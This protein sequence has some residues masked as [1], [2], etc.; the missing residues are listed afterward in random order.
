MGHKVYEVSELFLKELE[1]TVAHFAMGGREA[2]RSGLREWLSH[3]HWALESDRVEHG[4]DR[5]VRGSA[6]ED[7]FIDLLG[8]VIKVISCDD[9]EAFP[10][11][12]TCAG[13]LGIPNLG[14]FFF[15][16]A[17][18]HYGAYYADAPPLRLAGRLFRVVELRAK[19]PL[20]IPS[21][22]DHGLRDS[23]QWSDFED[24]LHKGI[25]ELHHNY[26][27][28]SAPPRT[29]HMFLRRY[30]WWIRLFRNKVEDSLLSPR[31][32]AKL[33]RLEE[34][35]AS[36][37]PRA[38]LLDEVLSRFSVALFPHDETAHALGRVSHGAH[39]GDQEAL[40]TLIDALRSYAARSY[41]EG[42]SSF[43]EKYSGQKELPL[44][45]RESWAREA[46][47]FAALLD[48]LELDL[49]MEGA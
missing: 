32:H 7:V 46:E 11:M 34:L 31:D 48:T 36:V 13:V 40:W 6:L 28:G 43:R 21:R 14:N 27:R 12:A 17:L 45:P 38:L 16:E 23:F 19:R 42:V 49:A 15:E 25:S 22:G 2:H 35:L 30:E 4:L 44:N 1:S 26:R 18:A 41:E 37:T 47:D 8:R 29:E 9:D 10:K 33:K 5:Y 24:E 39:R 3:P 20:P